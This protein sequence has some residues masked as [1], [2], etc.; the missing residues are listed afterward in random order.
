VLVVRFIRKILNSGA[1]YDDKWIPS[2]PGVSIRCLIYDGREQVNADF[3]CPSV[4]P[5]NTRV[6]NNKKKKK[7]KNYRYEEKGSTN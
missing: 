3:K 2:W 4:L 6:I 1:V 5:H 7:C